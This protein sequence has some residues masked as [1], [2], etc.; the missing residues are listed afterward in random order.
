MSWI[1]Q[2]HDRMCFLERFV[3]KNRIANYPGWENPHYQ[4]LIDDSFYKEHDKRIKRL[5]K[6]EQLLM[7]EMPIIPIYHFHAVY[8][9][10]PRLKKLAVS[11]MGDVQFH[12]AYIQ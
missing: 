7:D 10:N 4:Q 9:K 3:D 12:K 2:Y 5:D 8:V 1:G 11:P 6:A